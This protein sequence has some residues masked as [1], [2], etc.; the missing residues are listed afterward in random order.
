VIKL[1]DK[2]RE[3]Q[4]RMGVR[5]LHK[6][7]TERGVEVGRDKLFGTLRKHNKLVKPKKSFTKTTY[8]GHQYAVAPNVLKSTEVTA[9]R[10]AMVGDCTYLRL[11]GGH[12]VYLFLLTDYFSRKIV[13]YHLSK[14]LTHYGAVMALRMAEQTLGDTTGITHHTD[15][16]VQYCCHEYLR[17]LHEGGMVPSM[18]DENHC[19]QNAI[20][21]R[22]NGILKD[23]FDL[24]QVF[25][26][27]YAVQQVVKR[28][29]EVYNSKRRHFSL[30]LQTPD[31]VYHQKAL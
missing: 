23:E 11:Q 18:T 28:A 8:S 6:E 15:R 17:I 22:V 31:S 3:E 27:V 21:E 16:G 4:P 24:D 26:T 13:G 20:A 29:V 14:D 5:K 25:P 2:L 19:Y 1:V 30:E 9:P 7:F 12:F 10:Q